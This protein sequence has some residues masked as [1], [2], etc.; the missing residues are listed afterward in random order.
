MIALFGVQTNISL[1]KNM[2]KLYRLLY[3]YEAD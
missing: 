3:I 2:H 1:H